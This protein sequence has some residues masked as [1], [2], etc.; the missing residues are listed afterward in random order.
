VL[1]LQAS[2]PSDG[3]PGK[4]SRTDVY[5]EQQEAQAEARKQLVRPAPMAPAPTV[6]PE[7][8]LGLHGVVEQFDQPDLVGEVR[9]TSLDR[10]A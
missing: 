2:K 3:K 4:K 1:D 8:S 6:Q 7:T 10:K 9:V 5:R